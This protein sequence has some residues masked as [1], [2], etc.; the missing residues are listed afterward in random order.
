[1]YRNLEIKFSSREIKNMVQERKCAEGYLVLSSFKIKPPIHNAF[2]IG[3]TEIKPN[4]E[5]Q[6]SN[7]SFEATGFHL[8]NYLNCAQYLYFT[9]A[10]QKV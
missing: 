7:V 3:K 10:R 6:Q 4:H 1:M 5:T 2:G 8:L 9:I